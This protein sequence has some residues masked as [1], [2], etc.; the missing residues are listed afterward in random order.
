MKIRVLVVDDSAT[1]GRVMKQVLETIPC[2]D[3]AGLCRDGHQALERMRTTPLDLVTLDV[4]MPDMNGLDVLQAMKREGIKTT[5]IMVS[6]A[7]DRA[8]DLTLR[9][10]SLGALDFIQKPERGGSEENAAALREFLAPILTAAAHQ[11]E[12]QFILR[13]GVS[14]VDS[15]PPE[16]GLR[17]PLRPQ[18]TKPALVLIGVSTGGPQALARIIPGLPANLRVPVLIVQHMPP[19]FT[20]NLARKLDSCSGL[21]V[22]EAEDGEIALGGNVYI[23]PGGKHLKVTA[24]AQHEIFLRVT[25]DPPENNCRPAV[26]VLF[27]SAA[28]AFPGRSV[29]VILTGMG[30]DGTLGLRELRAKGVFSI[31]QDEATCT[32]FGMPKEVIEAGLVD[33]VVPLTSIASEIVKAI[34]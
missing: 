19:L 21:H 8:R 9:A 11:K 28:V 31:A 25:A 23:A 7:S 5:A 16:T 10:L 29:A 22:K 18:V 3:V 2:V 24:G 4:E 20:E 30:R 1:F 12:V 17:V 26:D 32:V 15:K 14:K 33:S 6:A 13:D 34:C 27:R